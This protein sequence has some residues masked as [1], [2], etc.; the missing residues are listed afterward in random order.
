MTQAS[1]R[2]MRMASRTLVMLFAD[3]LG[4]VVE[5]LRGDAGRKIGELRDFCGDSIGDCDGVGEA[6]GRC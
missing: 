6:G 2:P 4:L 1:M 3:E 5:G